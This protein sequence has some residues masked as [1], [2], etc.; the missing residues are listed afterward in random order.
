[1][2]E[3]LRP[4]VFEGEILLCEDNRMNQEQISDRLAKFGLK[5]IVAEN[6]KKGVEIVA[7]R[8]INGIKPFAL[9]FMDMYMPVMD[10]LEAAAE[11]GK[12]NTGTP[13]I[14]ITADSSFAEKSKQYADAVISGSL[15][16]PFT[17]KDLLDC[18]MKYLTPTA[19]G[20]SDKP[21]ED[22]KLR[23]K[24][25]YFFMES[26]RNI[27]NEIIKAI[28]EGD[29][30]TAHRFSHSLKSNADMLGKTRLKKAAEEVQN[31]LL[32]GEDL[33]PKSA[34]DWPIMSI[35][36]TELNAVLE[37]FTPLMTE[38]A[39]LAINAEMESEPLTEEQTRALLEELEALLDGGD[40]DC[41][42][43]I[44]DLRLIPESGG[45]MSNGPMLGQLILELVQQI[46]YFEF[47]KAMKTLL[48]LKKR[49]YGN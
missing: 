3:K 29:I 17:S 10:G 21:Q 18:L 24:L 40:T 38:T 46:E 1:M 25:I 34:A 49:V 20:A 39:L 30:K 7:S 15:N 23:T 13:I 27:Y 35:L 44:E 2:N 14:A 41:L 8:V 31:L 26:N 28:E 6:G 4:F 45:Q 33:S 9:I 43:L 12:L 48:R 16:K 36:K 22:E 42:D 47:D 5:T 32:S 37:E 19:Q 11:I